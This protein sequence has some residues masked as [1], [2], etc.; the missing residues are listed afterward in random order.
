MP[1][2]LWA[3]LVPEAEQRRHALREMFS[4]LITDA[5]RREGFV[6][7]ALD[8]DGPVGVAVWPAPGRHNPRWWRML[9]ALP[10]LMRSVDR[11]SRR[12][13]SQLGTR[14]QRAVEEAHPKE[15]HAYLAMIGIAPTAQGQGVGGLLLNDGLDHVD[16]FGLPTY[17][18]CE[19]HLRSYYER[20][21]FQVRHTISAPKGEVPDQLGMW[22]DPTGVSR[23]A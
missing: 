12:R 2:E 23:D 1:N 9:L 17:L 21:G 8:A 14:V 7:M 19:Q 18:E 15:R 5:V 16:S 4:P 11:A 20:A 6:R 22:R 13:L 10:G 3:T